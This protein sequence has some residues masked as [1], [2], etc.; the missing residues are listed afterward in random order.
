MTYI[1]NKSNT[2]IKSKYPICS[3]R[4]AILFYFICNSPFMYISCTYTHPNT[5]YF[6]HQTVV[7]FVFPSTSV[8]T[9]RLI[10]TSIHHRTLSINTNAIN[11]VIFLSLRSHS[12]CSCIHYLYFW[13]TKWNGKSEGKKQQNRQQQVIIIKKGKA[14]QVT[15][16]YSS[17]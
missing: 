1:F 13:H 9:W 4:R 7:L 17:K 6:T 2:I 14:N 8:V 5:I 15:R 10:C 16:K 3:L 12:I 11:I